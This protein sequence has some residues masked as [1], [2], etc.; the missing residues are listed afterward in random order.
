MAADDLFVE[1]GDALAFPLER[2][3]VL[4]WREVLDVGGGAVVNQELVAVETVGE[5]PEKLV[6]RQVF[7]EGERE[8]LVAAPEARQC[9]E[10]RGEHLLPAQVRRRWNENA[11]ASGTDAERRR[12][13]GQSRLIDSDRET[14]RRDCSLCRDTR[15]LSGPCYLQGLRCVIAGN[16]D[17]RVCAQA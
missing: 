2:G 7:L 10:G 9:A 1:L 3:C 8:V 14:V 13:R 11:G 17:S 4:L 6:A 15:V 5:G 12:K 16:G